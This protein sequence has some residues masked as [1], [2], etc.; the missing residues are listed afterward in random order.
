[1]RQAEEGKK[2]E[3]LITLQSAIKFNGGGM[4]ATCHHSK[5][6]RSYM[7]ACMCMLIWPLNA[8]ND[9]W[10]AGHINHSIFW[11]NLTPPKV[12][13]ASLRCCSGT[14]MH[15]KGACR[16]ERACTHACMHCNS[17]CIWD[18]GLNGALAGL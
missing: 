5:P 6:H 8:S 10:R 14:C 17:A 11:K 1:M 12:V 7:R 3:S 15:A 16:D 2:V 13:A 18:R 9:A 4:H